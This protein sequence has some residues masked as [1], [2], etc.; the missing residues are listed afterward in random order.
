VRDYPGHVFADLACPSVLACDA[1]CLSGMQVTDREVQN[2]IWRGDDHFLFR[3]LPCKC[4]CD[5]HT[6]GDCPARRWYGC[7][8]Q[9][10]VNDLSSAEVEAWVAHYGRHHGMS[11]DQFFGLAR[12]DSGQRTADS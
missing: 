8:G 9:S 2:A 5:E 11:R 3:A 6:F 1:Q 4:C 12:G 10:S 7:R